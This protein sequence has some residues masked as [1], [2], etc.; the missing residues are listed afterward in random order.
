M[1]AEDSNFEAASNKEM[2]L[3][4][5]PNN[6]YRRGKGGGEEVKH[7]VLTYPEMKTNNENMF[8]KQRITHY[9]SL[10]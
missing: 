2:E 7:W 1:G 4:T 9:L 10:V 8:R 3:G 6:G 5:H